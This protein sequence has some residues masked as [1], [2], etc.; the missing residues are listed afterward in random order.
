MNKIKY[1]IPVIALLYTCNPTLTIQ[2]NKE[3][4]KP[5]YL[6]YEDKLGNKISFYDYNQD[7]NV[8]LVKNVNSEGDSIK[9]TKRNK[10]LINLIFSTVI[11]YNKQP[12]ET[13]RVR[14]EGLINNYLRDL[15]HKE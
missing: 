14:L 2:I 7:G 5:K 8:D 4:F 9:V 10:D 1:F 13:E 11:D 12:L 6:L 15:K 3:I